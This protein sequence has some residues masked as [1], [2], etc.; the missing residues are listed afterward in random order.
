MIGIYAAEGEA[1]SFPMEEVINGYSSIMLFITV[2]TFFF[3][4]FF[5]LLLLWIYS[6]LLDLGC[7][8][9]FLIL[10]TTVRTQW[11]GD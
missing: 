1:K 9:S 5:L 2:T 3:F 4:F 10:Y 7:F 6:S 11:T 8:F